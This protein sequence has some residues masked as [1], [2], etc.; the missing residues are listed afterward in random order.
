MNFITS[1]GDPIAVSVGDI[2]RVEADRGMDAGTVVAKVPVHEFK[3]EPHTAGFRRRGY[4]HMDDQ[5]IRCIV[6]LAD[7]EDKRDL[8]NKTE[9]EGLVLQVPF[10]S[11]LT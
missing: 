9:D 4:K 8:I 3:A 2:V 11:L 5:R 1:T 10:R 6:K 7:E